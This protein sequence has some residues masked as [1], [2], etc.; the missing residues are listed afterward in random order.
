MA[1]LIQNIDETIGVKEALRRNS[2]AVVS[3]I[4]VGTS[5]MTTA[6][7]T[8]LLERNPPV[9]FGQF[10]NHIDGEYE[11]QNA[12]FKA[13]TRSNT[14][15]AP[16]IKTLKVEVD[17]PDVFD[18]GNVTTVTTDTVHV[19]FGRSFYVISEVVATLKSGTLIGMPR[20]SNVTTTGFDV[21]LVD[22]SGSR[23]A[24]L[25]SWIAKGC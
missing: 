13:R 8:V 5:D 17:L 24:G 16:V 14:G 19:N 20:V 22:P 1:D 23:I 9:G 21:D 6:D 12:V 2:M 7:F 25:V 18:R 4:Y 15:N 3:D 10:K 11:Y